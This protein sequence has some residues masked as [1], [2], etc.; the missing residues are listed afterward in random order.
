MTIYPEQKTIDAWAQLLRSQ[1]I[2]LEQAELALKQAK[3]P[4][5]AWYDI[6]LELHRKKETGL[7]QFEIG[8]RIL[9]RKHN[10]SRL[11][12]RLETQG[13]IIRRACA[14]DGR[15]NIVIITEPGSNL[16]KKMWPVYARVIQ[17]AFSDKLKNSE[18]KMLSRLLNKV[19]S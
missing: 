12:D 10:L 2:L 9:L 4:P 1:K 13:L 5:L 16:L 17:Q 19:L 11:L 15:G 6:L 14:E 3:L 18:I 8:E 7:R